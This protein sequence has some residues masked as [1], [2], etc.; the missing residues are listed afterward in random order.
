M[1]QVNDGRHLF[2][3]NINS[4][5]SQVNPSIA[6]H[7]YSGIVVCNKVLQTNPENS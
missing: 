7:Y 3:K 1:K 2:Q 6:A 5:N 4:I